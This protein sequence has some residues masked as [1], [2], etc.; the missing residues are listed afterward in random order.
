REEEIVG[1]HLSV[2]YRPEAES[3]AFEHLRQAEETGRYE[4]EGVRVR[5]DG[6]RFLSQVVIT[7]IKDESGRVW[8]FAKLTR[9]LSERRRLEAELAASEA[10]FRGI[11]EQSPV[12][13]WRTDSKGRYDYFNRTWCEF[14]G[15]SQAHEI[16]DGAGRL[17]A[18]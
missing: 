7:S 14:R 17:G 18:I 10:R 11:A 9:D 13:I 15:H 8:G 3:E 6:S 5:K 2:M 1:R 16:G 12:L 4:G